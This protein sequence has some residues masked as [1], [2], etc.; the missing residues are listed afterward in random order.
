MIPFQR[1][2]DEAVTLRTKLLVELSGEA[3]HV[4]DFLTPDIIEQ[5][6]E[7]GIAYVPKGST[8]LNGADALLRL[9]EN[10]IYVRDDASDAE[11]AYLVAHEL[12]HYVLD[13]G[14]DEM[15]IASLKS[16][17]T[18]EGSPAVKKVESYGARERQE[19]RA[20]VF[21]RELQ[22]PR[23][24]ARALY[25]SGVGPKKVANDYGIHLEIVQQQMLDA[26]MLPSMVA[27]TNTNTLPAP[28]PDQLKAIEA[29]ERFVNV[30]AGPGSGKTSTLVHRV[31][32]LVE[33]QGVEPSHILVLTF[34]NKAAFELIERLRDAGI[35]RASE[36]WAGTFHAF[37]LEFLRKYHQFFDLDSDMVVADKLNVI[38]LLN[39]ELSTLD[40][41]YYKRVQDPYEWLPNVVSGIQRLK[42]EMVTP[43]DYRKSL[44]GLPA[45][46][47]D[48]RI[49]REDVA[50]LYECQ[51]R[52]LKSEKLVDF[53]DLVSKPA[54]ALKDDRPQYGE[55][56]DKFQYVL[57]DEYQDVTFAMVEL[58][59]QLAKNAKSLWVVGDVRQAIHHWRGASVR[60]LFRFNQTFKE[61][62][63]IA[64]IRSYPLEFNRRSSAEILEV[65]QQVGRQHV[66][67]STP[68]KLE[69]TTA[70]AGETG[71]VPLLVQCTPEMAMTQAVAE[72][73]QR[74]HDD[75]V[76]YEKQAVLSRSNY[77]LKQ[78]ADGLRDKGIPVLYIGELAQRREVKML[79]CLM[80]VLVERLPRAL[81]GLMGE[82]S[83]KIDMDDIR[84]L[85][86]EC[87]KN[88]LLQRGGWRDNLPMGISTKSH[89][90]LANICALLQGKRR[91]STPWSF[92]CDL[93]LEWRFGYPNL[94]DQSID[95]HAVRI[96][97]WQ[98]A[99]ATRA[100]GGEGRVQTLSR[101]ILRQRLRQRI[102]ETYAE[103]ELP[104]EATGLEAVHLLTVHASKGLEFEAVHVANVNINDYGA[105][106]PTW[107]GEPLILTIVPPEALQSNRKEW[108][109]EAAVERNNLLYVAV[110]RAR[111]HLLM[112]ENGD[113]PRDRAPQ[114]AQSSTPYKTIKFTGSLPV[115]VTIP[116]PT[117]SIKQGPIPF[118]EFER[119]A[120]CPLQH[121]YYHD[122]EL[123]GEQQ[124]DIAIR[125][126]WAIMAALKSFS[127]DKTQSKSSLLE[128]MWQEQRLPSKTD[129]VQLWAHA[130]DVFAAGV[131]VIENSRGTYAEPV[132][133]ID[134]FEIELP[135]LLLDTSGHKPSIEFLRFSGNLDA[136]SS[137][138][139]PM[140][141]GLHP[142]DA[143]DLMMHSLLDRQHKK[144][145]HSFRISS[146]KAYKSILKLREGDRGPAT[147]YQCKWCAYST[148]CPTWPL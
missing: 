15:I 66:L 60:S 111:R 27:P 123:P 86:D 53:V 116:S 121:G 17:A 70:T 46:S 30:V 127:F 69:R 147:G 97:L 58:I 13:E 90:A 65:V 47:D 68:L 64:S 6:L 99:Y 142:V 96:A 49:Q 100:G 104:A 80:Q 4:S 33:E 36:I 35:T 12:G 103:R 40:L 45:S 101:F 32:Y 107:R 130:T 1:A 79:L 108:D 31:K 138:W 24:V 122:L 129:D 89:K 98:F 117:Q 119:Y 5:K 51:E 72:R 88:P 22:L 8:E 133:Q 95:A 92:V 131:R 73:V 82:P 75:G 34:T 94:S 74:M 9:S 124:I 23:A 136:A 2:R 78:I 106:A 148:L 83:L 87:A 113:E 54:N 139:R 77:E 3:T 84:I 125:A 11:K 120:R 105:E 55:L 144:F 21:A 132:T 76:S 38:T 50:T 7:L 25:K 115:N 128:A 59:R 44:P 114:L 143:K 56:A 141:N 10:Y 126:R 146:T 18:A 63:N 137:L 85:L 145:N 110:S 19:L 67:E 29:T 81:V 93:L 37:G 48:V 14:H 43:E 16:L 42:E 57:V 39:R 140:L 71:R 61:Y 62:G 41:Q 112:Y 52:V 102:G 26:V 91:Q 118:D 135:W 20:N 134:G 28:S 109:F